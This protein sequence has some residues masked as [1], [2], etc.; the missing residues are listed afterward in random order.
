MTNTSETTT[1]EMKWSD[2]NWKSV[3]RAVFRLQKRIY[4]ASLNGDTKTV[5]KLQKLLVK[6]KSAKLLAVRK[7][8]QSNITRQNTPGID[9]IAQIA[10]KI[11]LDG[12]AQP[13]RRIEI[14]QRNKQEKI[15]FGIPT[16]EDW[17]KQVLAKIALEP[18]WEA[19]FEANSYGFRPGK[20]A[21]DAI[22]AIYSDIKKTSYYVLGAE[23]EQCFDQINHGRLLDKLNTYPAMRRQIKAW[24][25]AGVIEKDV[26]YK[27][28]NGTAKGGV[29][30]P[31]L[32]NIA[33]H[34]MQEAL[35]EVFSE[36]NTTYG[37]QPDINF[38]P[39]LFHRYAG[40]FVIL[41]ESKKV[42]EECLEIINDYL[43]NIGLKLKDSTTRIAH[44]LGDGKVQTGFDYL[45][46]N[47]RQYPVKDINSAT[48]GNGNK[49]GFKTLIKPTKEAIKRHTRVLK[50]TIRL[51]RNAAQE[52]LIEVLT[53]KIREWSNYYD[54]VV[55]SRVFAKMDN[56]L[57]HQLLRWGYY[58][59]SMQGKKHTVN[60][61]WGVDKGQGWKFIT[62][63]GKV[64]R[65]HKESCSH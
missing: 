26:F 60:K 16:M 56:I 43:E 39:P 40:N 28:E 9:G 54:S 58:R 63:D 38:N 2:I 41:H 45:G 44:T 15:P 14:P 32:A 50:H 1:V 8:T 36:K 47:V 42:I 29:I 25:K 19:R 57:F 10:Q 53:P 61:Y 5:R 13:V 62:P 46:F 7:V 65:N 52:K 48:D 21:K 11:Q 49:L 20:S 6:S 37:I 4:K 30:S 34:G 22:T 59:A 18:E 33:L 51:Y 55:S 24:L 64:L 23:I 27:A 35:Q 12:K 3:N 17:S 31:L